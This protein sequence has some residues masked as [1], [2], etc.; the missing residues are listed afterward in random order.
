MHDFVKDEIRS[1]HGARFSIVREIKI[2]IYRNV[3]LTCKTFIPD[4]NENLLCS[5]DL[6]KNPLKL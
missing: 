4:Q 6:K 5:T 3:G 2:Y 1:T